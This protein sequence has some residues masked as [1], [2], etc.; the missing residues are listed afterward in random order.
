MR[1]SSSFRVLKKQRPPEEATTITVIR[2]PQPQ[3]PGALPCCRVHHQFP[4]SSDDKSKPANYAR[5][6]F[7]QLTVIA[8]GAP[9][10]Q[11]MPTPMPPIPK[12]PTLILTPTG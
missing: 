1:E 6:S 10:F 8:T 11:R 12:P 2:W 9:K 7:R 3:T 5:S 4:T